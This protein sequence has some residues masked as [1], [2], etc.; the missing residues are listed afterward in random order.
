MENRHGLTFQSAYTWSHSLGIAPGG[1][2]DF[3][4][5]SNPFDRRF[6]Y[7]PTA[8]DRR[9]ILSLNYI[10]QLPIFRN[11]KGL[12][13]SI[14]GGWE[15]SGI[16]LI[17]SGRP[18]TPGLNYDN[19]GLGGGVSGRPDAVGPLRRSTHGSIPLLSAVRRRC[20]SARRARVLSSAPGAR[21][22]SPSVCLSQGT[23]KEPIS[24]SAPRLSTSSTTTIPSSTD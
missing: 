4:Q 14:L 3:S 20:H 10:Y 23:R 17:Q 11:N 12:A 5:I 19:L 24:S 21:T 8:L 22:A 6:D 18:Y 15:F 16:T 1:G 9:H 7:G 2:G 13:G